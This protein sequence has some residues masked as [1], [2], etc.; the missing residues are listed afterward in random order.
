MPFGKLTAKQVKRVAGKGYMPTK[1]TVKEKVEKLTKEVNLLSP[2]FKQTDV[3]SAINVTDPT[4]MATIVLNAVGEG[5]SSYQRVGKKI[6]PVWCHVRGYFIPSDVAGGAFSLPYESIRMMLVWDKQPNG[7]LAVISDIVRD[8]DGAG[9]ATTNSQSDRNITNR[10]R[11]VILRD[12]R[13][14]YWFRPINTALANVS[15]DQPQENLNFEFSASLKGKKTLYN[16]SSA[17][18]TTINT[19]ALLLVVFGENASLANPFVMRYKTR[20]MYRDI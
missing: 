17:S 2:E 14:T 16:A 1:R 8:V 6:Q 3:T 12:I 11:F 15:V 9:G 5:A 18:I 10:D 20:F 13:K 4:T 7:S 19:G